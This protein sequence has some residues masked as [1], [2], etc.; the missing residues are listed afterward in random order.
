MAPD[1]LLVLVSSPALGPQVWRSTGTEL[2]SRGWRVTYAPRVATAPETA[3]DF[4]RALVTAIPTDHDVVL[5]PHS[6]A[7]LYVPA[8]VE[9]H[10]VVGSVFV[11]A[12]LPSLAGRTPLAPPNLYEFLRKLADAD[13][14]LPPW[15][16]WWDEAT[17]GLFPDATVRRAV[18]A[19]QPRLPLSYFA[20]SVHASSGW[21]RGQYAYL[22]FGDTYA[23]E[24]DQAAARGWP[25]RNLAGRHLQMLHDPASVA[26]AIVELLRD[27][28]AASVVT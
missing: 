1:P 17:A 21:D 20:G 27:L 9:R 7:G 5:V 3:A 6:N 25:V 4:I 19:E 15:T 8:L 2:S 22:A 28:A 16:E 12:G 26:T 13:G 24:R 10:Q 18:E 11:D 14:R 23:A